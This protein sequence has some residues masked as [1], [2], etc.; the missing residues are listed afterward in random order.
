[1]KKYLWILLIFL[2]G[3]GPK[4][5]KPFQPEEL[6]FNATKP[7]TLDLSSIQKPDKLQPIFVDDDFNEVDIDNA[8]YIVLTPKE[9][10]KIN[11]LL[12]IAT[13]YKKVALEQAELVNIHIDTINS[14]KEFLE[15]ER[16]KS[17]QYRELWINAENNYRYEKYEHS[18]DN[19]IN[20]S[21]MYLISIGSIILLAI[22][23]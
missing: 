2:I 3:C 17:L 9:Y 14:L 23:I 18:K 21:G 22:G 16:K 4:E 1:M 7:Y 13:T 20:K 19:F 5:F 12:K 15:L 11:T 8:F 6:N 10:G